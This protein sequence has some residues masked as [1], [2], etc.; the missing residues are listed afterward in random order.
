M[1][2]TRIS[3]P[4]YRAMCPTDQRVRST[5]KAS[6]AANLTATYVVQRLPNELLRFLH[7]NASLKNLLPP[8]HNPALVA[9]QAEQRLIDIYPIPGVERAVFD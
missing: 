9:L 7:D 6:T 2:A 3:L 5:G 8:P 1:A 4:R